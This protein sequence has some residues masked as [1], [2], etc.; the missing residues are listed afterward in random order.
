MVSRSG[1]LNLSLALNVLSKT[2]RVSRLRILRRTRVW[3][4]RAVGGLVAGDE[5]CGGGDG[6]G[7]VGGGIGVAAVVEDDVGG[8]AVAIVAVDFA[9]QLV[10]DGVGGGIFPVG[11]HGVPEDGREA[12]AAG[13]AE[14]CGAACSVGRT[15]E[16]DR[17]EERRVGKERRLACS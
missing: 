1:S 8:L 13:D 16:E 6:G 5:L 15:E 17:S 7:A 10:G 14:G 9:L 3:P 4:P 2:A 11:G 12:E